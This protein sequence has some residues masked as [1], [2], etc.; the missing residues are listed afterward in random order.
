V[1]HLL[2]GVLGFVLGVGAMV[3]LILLAERRHA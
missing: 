1:S 3:G 2:V